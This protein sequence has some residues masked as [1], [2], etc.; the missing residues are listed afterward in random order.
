VNSIVDEKY[1]IVW[2]FYLFSFLLFLCDQAIPQ[3]I[4]WST[5]GVGRRPALSIHGATLAE[6]LVVVSSPF[7]D[8]VR[9]SNLSDGT[10]AWSRRLLERVPYPTLPLA[11]AVVIQGDQGTL[12]AVRNEDGEDHWV[13]GTAEPTDYPMGP[14]RYREQAL[15]TISRRGVIRKLV[16]TGERL[17]VIRPL[18]WGE[19]RAET[20]PLR[21]NQ[22][23]LTYLDQAGRLTVYDSETLDLISMVMLN[24]DE[25]TANVLAG[26]MVEDGG[27]AWITEFSGILRAVRPTSGQALWSARLGPVEELW[28]EQGEL[29]AIPAILPWDEEFAVLIATQRQAEIY[30][31]ANRERLSSFALPSPAVAAPEFDATN[32]RTWLLCSRHLVSYDRLQGWR[33]F[34]LPLAEEPFSLA[35]ADGLI[36]IGDLQ[37]RIYGVSVP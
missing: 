7:G 11:D 33:S 35:L 17:S 26:A 20:V 21:S 10:G 31:G 34:E 28:S 12:W 24:P 9:A 18:S 29:L 16:G 6:Q 22:Q 14:P 5:P 23:Q 19:R 37:G 15:F 3:E 25:A 30:G 27:L 8:R 1:S 32:Q 13:I 36:V 4:L 2:K